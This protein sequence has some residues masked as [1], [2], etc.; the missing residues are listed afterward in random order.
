MW[1]LATGW[2]KFDDVHTRY[3][4]LSICT[5]QLI[6]RLENASFI[7]FGREFADGISGVWQCSRHSQSISSACTG[8]FV[9]ARAK[10]HHLTS[11]PEKAEMKICGKMFG[12]TQSSK[13]DRPSRPFETMLYPK[14]KSKLLTT[15]LTPTQSYSQAKQHSTPTGTN[16]VT[17]AI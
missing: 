8:K 10:G 1:F 14:L 12:S 3:S 11:V 9:A 13:A 6:Y 17:A 16:I 7:P 4:T 5:P 2:R 15:T